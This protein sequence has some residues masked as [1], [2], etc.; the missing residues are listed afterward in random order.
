MTVFWD[1]VPCSLVE[2]G[3]RFRDA[4]NHHQGGEK[5]P[6]TDVYLELD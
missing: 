6:A 2:I 5:K 4:Y 1:A 3:R